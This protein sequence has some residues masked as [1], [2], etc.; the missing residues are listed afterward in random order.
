MVVAVH[1]AA[2]Q[3]VPIRNRLRVTCTTTLLSAVVN[4]VGGDRVTVHTII[5]F[6][7]CPGHFDLTPGEAD[8]LRNADVL[9]YHGYEQ[10]LKGV[11][12]GSKTRMVK[13]GVKGNWLIPTVHTQAVERVRAILTEAMPTAGALFAKRAE[14][15][16]RALTQ[17]AER[18]I[19][20]L[21]A[22]RG[23]PV[24][25]A[26]M[27]RD[28]AEWMGCRVVAEFA[29]DEDVSVKA[30]HGILTEA[31]KSG[32]ALVIDNM[33][34][35]GKIG[36]TIADEL[37]IPFVMLSNFPDANAATADRPPCLAAVSNNCATV[38]NALNIK[39]RGE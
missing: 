17:Q 35:S 14:G 12:P 39:A 9:L 15:Y 33:Q 37:G 10:F 38:Q 30:L 7:M 34:S 3:S 25:C 8:K 36:R 32:A 22:V 21:A 16:S 6:G 19:K 28:L 29:R 24:V 31:K 5:P 1:G 13:A 23:T 27:N 20:S 2:N 11:E 26:T 4:A 18:S